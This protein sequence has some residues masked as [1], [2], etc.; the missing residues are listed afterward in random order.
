[1]HWLSQNVEEL[2]AI[3]GRQAGSGDGVD[4][5]VVGSGYGGAVAAMRFAQAGRTVF[6]L[7]RGRE[8]V[9]GEFPNDLSQAGGHVRVEAA[10]QTG[11]S[12]M[13][14]EDAL[15]DFRIGLRA[16]ALQRIVQFGQPFSRPPQRLVHRQQR[17]R[18][19]GR[20]LHHQFQVLRRR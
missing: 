14:N 8:Y 2:V 6:V 7:E 11:V 3:A 15:F 4:V 17:M 10:A 16:G 20:V 12:V 5:V 18:H 13:G 1:M 9:A 19:R